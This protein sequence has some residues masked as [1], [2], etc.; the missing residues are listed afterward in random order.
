MKANRPPRS[1]DD[2]PAQLPVFPLEGALLLPR[3]RLPLNIFE[4][5]YLAMIDDALASNRLIG[6]VQPKNV[7]SAYNGSPQLL[8]VGCAGRISQFA[9][10]GDGRYLISLTGVARFRIVSEQAAITP[11]RKCNVAF[12][13]FERDLEER[14]GEE[15]VDR[16]RLL[17]LLQ[18]FAS[19][20]HVMIDWDEI[21][22]TT[23]EA[24]VNALAMISPFGPTEKQA[25]LEAVTLKERADVLMAITEMELARG[26]GTPSSLQ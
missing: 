1:S 10:T 14:R 26:G 2:L 3:G 18:T 16:E 4:P 12:A 7:V 21:Q 20:N 5:R 24:L 11:Y 17:N 6:L 22:K 23:N 19:T 25:L 8:S 9:E 15:E 13:E